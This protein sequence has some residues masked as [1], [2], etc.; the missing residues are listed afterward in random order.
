MWSPI[1]GR[2]FTIWSSF[3]RTSEGLVKLWIGGNGNDHIFQVRCSL[4]LI[5]FFNSYYFFSPEIVTFHEWTAPHKYFLGLQRQKPPAMPKYNIRWLGRQVSSQAVGRA[6]CHPSSYS[7]SLLFIVSVRTLQVRGAIVR[8]SGYFGELWTKL[9]VR[10]RSGSRFRTEL[11]TVFGSSLVKRARKWTSVIM[12][13]AA[14]AVKF[15]DGESRLKKAAKRKDKA[16]GLGGTRRKASPKNLK[17]GFINKL[18]L[19]L[20][21]FIFSRNTSLKVSTK[22]L[23]LHA[24]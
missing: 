12:M 3:A 9:S 17:M 10:F 14:L 11:I 13:S 21:M 20:F 23:L 1:L 18:F 4:S 5:L 19:F 8:F 22:Y 16:R 24:I 15:H 2:G 7:S 6:F